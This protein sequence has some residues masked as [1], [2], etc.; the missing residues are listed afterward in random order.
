[1]KK[2]GF[3]LT[4]TLEIG[5]EATVISY[6][7]A[8]SAWLITLQSLWRG[9]FQEDEDLSNCSRLERKPPELSPEII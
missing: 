5:I 4:F 6:L 2:N 8:F 3:T 7:G 1:L 9:T